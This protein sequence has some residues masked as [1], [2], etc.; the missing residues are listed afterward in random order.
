MAAVQKRSLTRLSAISSDRPRY[1][2]L[3]LGPSF[4]A[5][6]LGLTIPLGFGGSTVL[7]KRPIAFSLSI[8]PTV[9]PSINHLCPV[10]M[11]FMR[12]ASRRLP[13]TTR[14][15]IPAVESPLQ[16]RFASTQTSN[17]P[18]DVKSQAKVGGL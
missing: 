10:I 16:R 6:S 4:L 14:K 1:R 8:L 18:Q 11:S 5:V 9:S 15:L 13:L 3:F 2:G 17:A 7:F 12:V